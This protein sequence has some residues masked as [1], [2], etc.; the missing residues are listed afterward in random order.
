MAATHIFPSF[1]PDGDLHLSHEIA[2]GR[3]SALFALLAG[4]GLALASGGTRPLR[5][6][7]LRAARAGV[8]ARACLL[9]TVGLLLGEIE[10]PP[11]VILAYY[12]LLFLVAVP[13]L[14]LS[15]R[16]LAW[17][18]A[19]AALLTPLV[20]HELRQHVDPA[21]IAEPGGPDLLVELFLTGT[22]PVLTWTTYLFAGLAVGRCDLRRWSVATRLVV[23]GLVA[24]VSAR[25]LS[26]ALLDAVGGAERL[27]ASAGGLPL[28]VEDS[29]D[30]GLF[31]TT[32]TGDWRWLTVSA[33]HSG[34]T[35][36]LVHTTGTA[37]AVLGACLLLARVLPRGV[38]LPFAAAGSMTFT[39]Y[40][41]HVLALSADSPFLSQDRQQLWLVQVVLAL[42]VATLWRSTI[43]RGPLEALA[44]L[45]DRTARRAVTSRRRV[46]VSERV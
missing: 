35:L 19:G 38:L 31:G 13:V 7:G 21:P 12:A 18:A 8:V 40:T 14:G 25:V 17:L 45:L 15:A 27:E 3:A 4:V 44:A 6:V 46:R 20:S 16:A 10:S 30:R 41:A 32:P 42:L 9:F 36:D 5:G 2:S 37:L 33:P 24:A 26:T 11:L 39:L 1:E 43:G 23:L 34:T 28:S 29:L 22:Y